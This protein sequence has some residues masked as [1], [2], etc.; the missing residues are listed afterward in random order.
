M[1]SYQICWLAVLSI[2]ILSRC[3]IAIGS[4]GERE[5]RGV[6]DNAGGDG[7]L[8]HHRHH[9][10]QH[11][12]SGKSSKPSNKHGDHHRQHGDSGKSSE[13]SN[14]HGNHHRQ[15]GD[16]CIIHALS[17]G[18]QYLSGGVT[19][20]MP[21]SDKYEVCRPTDD[22]GEVKWPKQMYC[23]VHWIG[24][25]G[26][27][28]FWSPK[29]DRTYAQV[30]QEFYYDDRVHYHKT[31]ISHF[32]AQDC[33]GTN[34]RDEGGSFRQTTSHHSE[35]N[36]IPYHLLG[37]AKYFHESDFA[38]KPWHRNLCFPTITDV[39]EG[40]SSKQKKARE[41][42]DERQRDKKF[43]FK[44]IPEYL[45]GHDEKDLILPE[46]G[47]NRL[48]P[49]GPPMFEGNMI[50]DSLNQCFRRDPK[51]WL[52]KKRWKNSLM[53]STTE[54]KWFWKRTFSQ[55]YNS[56]NDVDENGKV[57]DFVGRRWETCAP[58][59]QLEYHWVDTVLCADGFKYVHH[60][61]KKYLLSEQ[62]KCGSSCD[63]KYLLS[64]Q[65]KCRPATDGKITPCIKVVDAIGA[66]P[67]WNS[68]SYD[69]DET[70][71]FTKEKK[72][73][74]DRYKAAWNAGLSTQVEGD[75]SKCCEMC[76][77]CEITRLTGS[78]GLEEEEGAKRKRADCDICATKCE[79]WTT[80]NRI[81]TVKRNK[82]KQVK[83]RYPWQKDE[84]NNHGFIPR[85][86]C[87][88]L[89]RIVET[90][91]VVY[92]Q[93][94]PSWEQDFT[95]GGA[96]EAMFNAYGEALTVKIKQFSLFSQFVGSP[97]LKS[98]QE[99]R[100]KWEAAASGDSKAKGQILR[101][102]DPGIWDKL[103]QV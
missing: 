67:W 13:T 32:G 99:I 43:T 75:L 3:S 79:H 102:V 56:P 61:D 97:E 101:K 89:K 28:S 18:Y 81:V 14:K 58:T 96:W 2:M 60:G 42:P 30:S 92:N 23:Q 69:R 70:R 71:L 54:D 74:V 33:W 88:S 16:S 7:H 17:Q 87:L 35:E 36:R 37:D 90:G 63:K 95:A 51:T 25:Y 6:S 59:C 77:V 24:P 72:S 57:N 40:V 31:W 103:L 15:H 46:M 68:T 9:H 8:K 98:Q 27:V 100:K 29:I 19:S 91:T 50:D 20:H 11:G 44:S 55:Y 47:A 1:R 41:G 78:E 22:D 62:W 73:V 10:R 34:I 85:T 52:N 76:L 4:L 86:D 45:K 64:E 26:S 5:D 39:Y 48:G 80:Y 94:C 38:P 83:Y 53:T 93:D 21:G 12:D 65:W 84:A 66:C 49:F 82:Y